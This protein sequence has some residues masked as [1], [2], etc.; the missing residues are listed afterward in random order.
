MKA[1]ILADSAHD[2]AQA[3]EAVKVYSRVVGQ[4][5]AGPERIKARQRLVQLILKMGSIDWFTDAEAQASK[6]VNED[7]A[8]DAESHRLLAEAL[9]YNGYFK[10]NNA[11]YDE[12]A[13]EYAKAIAKAPTDVKINEQFAELYRERMENPAEAEKLLNQLVAAVGDD[14]APGGGPPRPVPALLPRE[15]YSGNAGRRT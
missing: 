9:Q 7:H 13:R 4:A 1:E 14:P 12:S 11:K 15:S 5:P 10:K 2:F 8:D 6:L 3:N